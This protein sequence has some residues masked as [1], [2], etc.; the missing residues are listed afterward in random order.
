MDLVPPSALTTE[1][2]DEAAMLLILHL[3]AMFA[4]RVRDGNDGR[5]SPRRTVIA[6]DARENGQGVPHCDGRAIDAKSF[7]NLAGANRM[8]KREPDIVGKSQGCIAT[9][10][11]GLFLCYLANGL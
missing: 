5:A 1:N 7:T 8:F 2:N 9:K 6:H 4:V 11:S 3:W 10:A